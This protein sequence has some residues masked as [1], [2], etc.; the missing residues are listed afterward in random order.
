M[1]VT[2]SKF[3]KYI[4][5]CENER[6]NG[7]ACCQP[8]GTRIR[9]R[10]KELVKSA[11]LAAKIRVSRSGC[12]DVCAEGPS[13]LIMP[14]NVRLKKAAVGDAERILDIARQNIL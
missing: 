13:V 12:H 11:G 1:E 3:A 2:P 4:F 10:L 8:E 9:E 14:D 6:P 5:I 7:E